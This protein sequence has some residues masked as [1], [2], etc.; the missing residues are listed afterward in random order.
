[1]NELEHRSPLH[2][3][4]PNPRETV[5]EQGVSVQDVA[6]IAWRRLGI[7]VLILA[8]SLLTAAF[9]SM[10]TPKA[11]RANAQVLLVQ[12]GIMPLPSGQTNYSPPMME[13]ID[14][15]ITLMQSRELAKQAA[16]TVGVDTDTLLG[17]SA[18][19]PRRDGDNVIDVAVE[20]GSRQQAVNWANALC[21][22]FV[23]YKKQVAQRTGQETLMTLQT[24]SGQARK[25]MD[26]A[27]FQLLSFQRTHR[28]GNIN[29]LDPGTQ[30]TAALNAVIN[31][32]T[33]V[34]NLQNESATAE[35]KANALSGQLDQA[36]AAI[37][38]S[39][40]VRDDTEVKKLQEN[41][42]D[43][44]QQ[45]D[46]LGRR[47][48]KK[49]PGKLAPLD[50]QIEFTRTL[51]NQAL[52]ALQTQPNLDALSA[53]QDANGNA[54]SDALSAR[55]RLAAAI[56]QRGVLE[57][58]TTNLPKLGMQA[59]KLIEN[60]DQAHKLFNTLSAATQAAQL[61]K[62]VASGNVQIV[63]PAFAPQTPFRPNTRRDLL[64]GLGIGVLLS[65]L[66]VLLLEQG[67]H[68]LRSAA[69]VRRLASGPV[70][71]VLP[72]MTRAQRGQFM[73]GETPPHLIETYNAV[74]AN[75][76]IAMR[77]LN[78]LDLDGHQV[79]LV[80]SAIPGEGKSLT[81]TELAQSY[82]RAGQR[83]VLVDAD[84]RRSSSLPLLKPQDKS[85]P[86]LAEVLQGEAEPQEALVPS[87]TAN[88][89][90]LHSG[91]AAQNPIDL[92][93]QPRMAQTIKSLREVA[94]VI[95]MD[96][97]PA[98]MVADALLLAPHADCVLFVVGVGMADSDSVRQTAAALAAASP[99]MLA[100]FV[101]RVP[102]AIGEPASYAYADYGATSGMG[103]LPSGPRDY[104]ASR[105]MS[106]DREFI[107]RQNEMPDPH[108]LPG[109][110]TGESRAM[111]DSQEATG[112]WNRPAVR[113]LP[114]IGSHFVTLEGPYSGQKFA[115]SP[116][117]MLTIGILPDND[118]V[119]ARDVTISRRHARV[120]A[121]EGGYVVYDIGATNGTFVNNV[122]VTRQALRVGDVVQFG[123]SKFRYE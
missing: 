51:L 28:I 14:T 15:Q 94:D 116:T 63:Q 19:T 67:D 85:A 47:Y 91:H 6:L 84:M 55:V 93:S 56:R 115:L 113:I 83:V 89:S 20:A 11:W 43:L 66:A 61:D 121:E 37:K 3:F 46:A 26:A 88:L 2:N 80:T 44:Q 69:D 60:A 114:Q 68:S 104:Q 117:R 21:E 101:N 4:P 45:R 27:D 70:V 32:D 74:R 40:G 29:F 25:N 53:L 123:A 87:K 76:G 122:Q 97:P 71:A 5:A 96:S 102:H 54:R 106:L 92:I 111:G 73:N 81:A 38:N 17:A 31:Q 9:V 49:F 34:A 16:Q 23:Q 98:A 108:P 42:H 109:S 8:V 39:N 52:R 12:R 50:A 65:L 58:Q 22:T 95:I 13:S 72:Q 1:M 35:A 77:R 118:I 112:I 59:G 18:I 10:R 41:L 78:G 110:V 30:R 105:T 100:Y 24:Q 64:V 99:K 86:G 36:K 48:T 79:I 120:A 75:L 33:V 7:I 103:V 82:A 57:G 90:V 62:D 119:L 107:T